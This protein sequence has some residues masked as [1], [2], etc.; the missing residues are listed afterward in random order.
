MQT[1]KHRDYSYLK[2]LCTE[3]RHAVRN[4]LGVPPQKTLINLV[5]KLKNRYTDI[6][7]LSQMELWCT[8]ILSSGTPYG[9]AL[10]KTFRLI[11]QQI[12]KEEEE[13]EE[14]EEK[15]DDAKYLPMYSRDDYYFCK[16]IV[17]DIIND[18]I[19]NNKKVLPLESINHYSK[20]L[21]SRNISSCDL[22]LFFMWGTEDMDYDPSF[23]NAADSTFDLI[24]QNLNDYGD[25]EPLEEEENRIQE[26][27]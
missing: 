25:E 5:E 21:N 13:E 23:Q 22:S 9:V 2:N 14:E 24:Y 6:D 3:I 11:R 15:D 18:I 7:E 1:P 16:G 12:E 27:K 19:K 17:F 8:E 26:E 20:I 4:N 10:D